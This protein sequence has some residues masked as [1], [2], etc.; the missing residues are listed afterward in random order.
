MKCPICGFENSNDTKFCCNC[1]KSFPCCPTCGNLITTRDRFCVHDGTRLS[2]E[3]LMLVPDAEEAIEEVDVA[4]V[5]APVSCVSLENT[6]QIPVKNTHAARC[7]RCGSPVWQGGDYCVN[8]QNTM[9]AASPTC[10]SCGMP[11]EPGEEYCTYCRPTGPVPVTNMDYIAPVTHERST[12][13]KKKKGSAFTVILVIVLLLLIGAAAVLVAAE[14]DL[15]ELPD[16]LAS[17]D[18]GTNRNR[19]DKDED[20]DDDEDVD[21]DSDGATSPDNGGNE[22]TIST[23]PV[24]KPTEPQSEPTEPEPKPTQSTRVDLEFFME[25]CGKMYFDRADIEGFTEDEC[26]Y[27]RNACY[28]HAGRMFKT[29]DLQAYFEQYDWYEPT[30]E[31]SYFNTYED[32]LMNQYEKANRKLISAY[33]K[34]MGYN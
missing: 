10:A 15:I 6:A 18:A 5:A 22:D 14:F 33:E 30:Y 11:C 20:K 26:Y 8:C 9:R 25:N 1:G 2:D 17:D 13:T 21:E 29:K 7:L 27:A 4:Q 31:P 34:E 32:Y 24:S 16:F 23:E 19:K 3:L 12:G 28:A